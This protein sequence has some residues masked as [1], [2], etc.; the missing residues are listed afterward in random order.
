M[1][2]DPTSLAYRTPGPWGAGDGAGLSAGAI[3]ANIRALAQAIIDLESPD[4]SGIPTI[5]SVTMNGTQLT[6]TLTDG[7]VRGPYLIPIGAWNYRSDWQPDTV[8]RVNDVV[9]VKGT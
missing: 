1:P 5:A 9:R 2:L 8:Y 3:D 7:T 6:V 4:L